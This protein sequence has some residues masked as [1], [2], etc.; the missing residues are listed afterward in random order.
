M[1]KLMI[2]SAFRL[3]ASASLTNTQLQAKQS[4][5]IWFSNGCYFQVVT[6]S[7]LWGLIEWEE[8]PSLIGCG[9]GFN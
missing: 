5:Y 3:M 4:S 1:K 2:M 7:I 9:S 8:E 6:H